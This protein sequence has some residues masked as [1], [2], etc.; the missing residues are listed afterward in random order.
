MARDAKSRTRH[1]VLGGT[2]LAH[3]HGDFRGRAGRR[4]PCPSRSPQ[5]QCLPRPLS[6]PLGNTQRTGNV[7][8]KGAR[9]KARWS[10]FEEAL[11]GAG[12]QWQQPGLWSCCTVP[13]WARRRGKEALLPIQPRLP[14]HRLAKA[15]CKGDFGGVNDLALERQWAEM[16]SPSIWSAMTANYFQLSVDRNRSSCI[17]LLLRQNTTRQNS[18]Q[19]RKEKVNWQTPVARHSTACLHRSKTRN[20]HVTKAMQTQR[21]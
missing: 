10:P 21:W 2:Q 19:K 6:S 14:D 11:W 9:L 17:C 18:L 20:T 7:A 13:A 12:C 5:R 16:Q 8:H 4:P 1:T 3:G 15:A